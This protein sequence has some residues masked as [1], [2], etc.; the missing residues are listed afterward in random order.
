[1]RQALGLVETK[2]ILAAIEASDV[3]LK[4]AEVHLLAKERVGG[5]I[6]TI[7]VVGDVSAVKTAV[8]A[9]ASAVQRLSKDLLLSALVIPNP[10]QNLIQILTDFCI[11]M[12]ED[13][14]SD[15][16]EMA[17]NRHTEATQKISSAADQLEEALKETKAAETDS[18][19]EADR[20]LNHAEKAENN[21]SPLSE[22]SLAEW[23]AEGKK[24]E[25]QSYLMGLKAVELKKM[26]ETFEG[27]SL[28][29]RQIARA[30]KEKL[31]KAI[32]AYFLK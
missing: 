10:D 21:L 24:V 26:A 3:M 16:K 8:D 9:G 25:V 28:D 31:S 30:S 19:P 27:I 18:A 20:I 23:L 32:V 15:K 29:K 7:E 2:G 17:E 12:D 5:G 13:T 1:M 6:V 4:S 11:N 22:K 14:E